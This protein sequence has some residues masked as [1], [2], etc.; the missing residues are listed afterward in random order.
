M[1]RILRRNYRNASRRGIALVTAMV[2]L[3]MVVVLMS[4]IVQVAMMRH[5]VAR[6]ELR[7]LQAAW[8]A[9]S[10]LQRAAARLAADRE[11]AGEMWKIGAEAFDGRHAGVVLIEVTAS[12]EDAR[13]RI[14]RVRADFPDDPVHRARRS[15]QITVMLPPGE[16][17]SAQTASREA[18]ACFS[19]TPLSPFSESYGRLA[20]SA[21]V[22]SRNHSL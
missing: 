7:Q 11:Y 19:I 22:S 17:A 2:C 10:A 15:K 18:H 13:R 8:L 14:V 20:H 12:D 6:D 21:A 3:A 9:D 1:N 4:L 5:T 16:Q